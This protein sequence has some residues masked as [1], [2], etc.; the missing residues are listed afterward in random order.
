M[1][2]F[3]AGSAVV[4]IKGDT[5]DFEG[6]IARIS[7]LTKTLTGNFKGLGLALGAIGF[8]TVALGLT[9]SVSAAIDYQD[10]FTGVLKNYQW[11]R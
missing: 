6:D 5:T 7:G 11:S 2:T 9:K 4:R 3:D 8:S 1:A 10:A